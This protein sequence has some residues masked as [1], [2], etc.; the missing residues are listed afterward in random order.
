[1]PMSPDEK[2]ELAFKLGR[3]FKP[4][5]P[6][7][8][9]EL[10]SGRQPQVRD[11]VDAVNQ[12]GRHVILYGERGVGKTS[13]ANVIFQYL[14]AHDRDVVA[15]HINCSSADTFTSIWRQ[16]FSELAFMASTEK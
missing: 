2:N 10:F 4:A 5:T 11:V 7:N 14:R 6:V 3:V 8:S 15:P 16:V 1:M 9:I 12:N 13:L